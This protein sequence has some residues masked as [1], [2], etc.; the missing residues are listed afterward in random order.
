MGMTIYSRT[1][2]EKKLLLLLL[3]LSSQSKSSKKG[4]QAYLNAVFFLCMAIL[5]MVSIL[6]VFDLL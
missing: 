2:F 5:R 6:L 4:V 3:L 1:R